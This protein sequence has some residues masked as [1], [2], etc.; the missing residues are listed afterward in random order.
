[1]RA[2][3]APPTRYLS[4]SS[5]DRVPS[6]PPVDA[7]PPPPADPTG[8]DGD[9]ERRSA[10]AT[11]VAAVGALLMLA[12]A[13]TFLAVTWDSLGL[14]ARVAVVGA[15]TVGATIGGHRLRRVL[16]AVGAVVFHLGALLVPIDA[17]GLALQLDVSTAGVWI[18]VG[19]STVVVLPL[20][21]VFGRSWPLAVVGLIGVPVLAT[22][23][24]LAG[25]LVPAVVT[26]GV[27]AGLLLVPDHTGGRDEEARRP[28]Q[29]LPW[30]PAAL[31]ATTAV[32]VATGAA[33]TWGGA[34]AGELTAGWA[35]ASWIEVATSAVGAMALGVVAAVRHR[36]ASTLG[37]LLVTVVAA[38]IAVGVAPEAPRIARILPL[39]LAFLGA[40]LVAAVA[41][42]GW[43]AWPTATSTRGASPASSEGSS[44]AARPG[45]VA[46]RLVVALEVPAA[47]L[48]LLSLAL[49]FLWS[50]WSSW[51]S[52]FDLAAATAWAVVTVGWVVAVVRRGPG[53]GA[54]AAATAGAVTLALTLD[55]VATPQVVTALVLV[56]AA[57]ATVL[58]RG[59]GATAA[60]TAAT[61]ALALGTV[62]LGWLTG[63]AWEVSPEAGPAVL[64][65]PFVGFAGATL[66]AGWHVRAVAT[67]RAGDGPA[68][69]LVL[70]VVGVGAGIHAVGAGAGLAA[71]AGL[72][73]L[74]IVTTVLAGGSVLA[75]AALCE[76]VPP[77]GDTI[78]AASSLL[79]LLG[80]VDHLFVDAG[81]TTDAAAWL[82]AS[83]L[84][85]LAIP[86]AAEAIRLGR[87]WLHAAAAGLV[88]RGVWSVGDLE[89]V[90]WVAVAVGAAVAIGGAWQ[91]REMVAHLGGAIA[92][93]GVWVLLD[94]H[95]V[96]A[97]DAWLLGP[98][99][100][101]WA[102]G[103][104][105]RRRG[106]G[107]SW[108]HD[109]PPLLL[110]AIPA[111]LARMAGGG[112]WHAVLAGSLG[113]VAVVLGGSQRLAGP[114]VV[115]TALVSTVVLVEAFAVV[116]AVPTWAWLGIG[117]A[118]LLGAAIAIERTDGAP[119]ERAKRLLATVEERFD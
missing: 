49:M 106:G 114:L 77:A 78:R 40:Q 3:D 39:P 17:L 118:V 98:A 109:V 21:A 52:A 27:A 79:L 100:Q 104:L 38:A 85:L 42:R 28:E 89:V 115:G 60:R 87:P 35:P 103:A 14:P 30:A 13:A 53:A 34:I 45:D 18:A 48:A 93:L 111:L 81:A 59:W 11:W 66:L 58:T 22:G 99:L 64:V 116:A 12:A 4:V 107:S 46:S 108:V 24:G 54:V 57:G 110:V 92:N 6:G 67:E 51:S 119:V 16:P 102:A 96:D 91:R 33:G 68:A 117:G 43:T 7:G 5:S 69:A 37:L 25:L 56:V 90:G 2:T 41:S 112:G 75:L 10:A 101:L 29:V 94:H 63:A 72:P 26:L 95:G 83:T 76:R 113:V 62:G 80:P 1:M 9:G 97:V 88:L 8:G 20:L 74:A 105:A 71:A 47:L 65:L 31:A 73:A 44:T 61:S 50:A 36:R 70:G 23:L 19:A 55:A 86:V 32:L 82:T 84:A 15:A